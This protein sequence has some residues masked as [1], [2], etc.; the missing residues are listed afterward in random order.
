MVCLIGNDEGEEVLGWF[1]DDAAVVDLHGGLA[2]AFGTPR[3]DL[4]GTVAVDQPVD[5]LASRTLPSAPAF[6]V[7]GRATTPQPVFGGVLVP[8]PD[9]VL[10]LATDAGGMLDIGGTWP[11]TVPPGAQVGLQ[12]WVADAG[13]PAGFSASNT[14]LITSP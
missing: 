1:E 4:W 10:P 2:G 8:T 13:G 6:L 7:L 5:V 14:L 12:L 3:L 9:V 11:V